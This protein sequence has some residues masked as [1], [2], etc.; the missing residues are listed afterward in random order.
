MVT[1][2]STSV[3]MSHNGIAIFPFM[4]PSGGSQAHP[5]IPNSTSANGWVKHFVNVPTNNWYDPDVANEFDF[6]MTNSSLFTGIADFPTGFNSPF[7]VFG[8]AN[9]FLGTYGPG[10]SV[11]FV[12]LLG[13]GVSNFKILGI[14]PSVDPNDPGSF[15]V[16][17]NFNT[18]TASFD[19]TAVPEPSFAG[20]AGFGLMALRRR[21][22]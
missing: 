10:Q 12:T 21:R 20:L 19:M 6:Q 14:N 11:N 17:L 15:A 4:N 16:Q 7:Q 2:G 18:S 5:T 3:F 22:A 1:D 13:G 9:Q 8:P